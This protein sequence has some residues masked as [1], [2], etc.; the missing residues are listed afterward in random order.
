[1]EQGN[2][3]GER[4]PAETVLARLEAEHPAAQYD[5]RYSNALELLVAAILSAQA[6]DDQVNSVTEEL[7]ARY[8]TAEDYANASL[9]QL[10]RDLQNVNFYRRKA[11]AIRDACREILTEHDGQVPDN[12]DALTQLPGVGRKTANAILINA[13]DRAIGIVVDTHVMR[14]SQRLGFTASDHPD[15]IEADLKAC[16]PEEA[17]KHV[18]WLMKYHGRAVCTPS[19]PA[20][21]DCVLGDVCPKIGV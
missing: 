3:M 19:Q 2:A 12:M 18:T 7:F 14:L 16:I 6:R 20:C 17:W 15:R 10:E 5:L 9:E 4:A 1:M 8:F 11:R 13:F 21:S